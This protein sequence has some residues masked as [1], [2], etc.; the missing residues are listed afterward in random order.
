MI[1]EG[2]LTR[3]AGGIARDYELKP[4]GC[5]QSALSANG[6]AA[7]RT[8]WRIQKVRER[9]CP[10]CQSAADRGYSPHTDVLHRLHGCGKRGRGAGM[11]ISHGR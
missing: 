9:R 3:S 4:A 7:G 11:D 2:A 8:A 1:A 5:A 10:F 6:I